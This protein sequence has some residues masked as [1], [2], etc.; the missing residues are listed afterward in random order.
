MVID[1]CS[2]SPCTGFGDTCVVLGAVSLTGFDYKCENDLERD[3]CLSEPCENRG[4][5][6]HS[7]SENQEFVCY[8][9]ASHTGL[10]GSF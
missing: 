7:D 9:K 8:C 1:A 4:T 5:C 3:A 6:V 2:Y 10:Q